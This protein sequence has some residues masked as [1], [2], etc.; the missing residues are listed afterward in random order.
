MQKQA[1]MGVPIQNNA[2]VQALFGESDAFL[3]IIEEDFD[4]RVVLKSDSI[5]VLGDNPKEVNRVVTVLESLLHR[6]RKG[7]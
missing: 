1:I 7:D 4:V 5:A 3:R 6:I 2:E